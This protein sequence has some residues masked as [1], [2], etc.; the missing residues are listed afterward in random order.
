MYMFMFRATCTQMPMATDKM[1]SGVD[2]FLVYCALACK[3]GSSK[4]VTNSMHKFIKQ[5]VA[6]MSEF[7]DSKHVWKW[8]VARQ[9]V[10][11]ARNLLKQDLFILSS[12]G[13]MD[14]IKLSHVLWPRVQIWVWLSL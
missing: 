12:L 1:P 3:G 11:W 10:N 13:I 6:T 8:L 9:L 5:W 4:T 14:S 7:K 2:N